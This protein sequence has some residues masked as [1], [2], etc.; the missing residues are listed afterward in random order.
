MRNCKKEIEWALE[1]RPAR[2][3]WR[4]VRRERIAAHALKKTMR[5]AIIASTNA[6]D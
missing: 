5:H 2:T 4:N 3:S 6:I 1:P